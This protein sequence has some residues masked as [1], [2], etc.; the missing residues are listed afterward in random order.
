MP[1]DLQS[2]L[3]SQGVTPL[4]T[5]LFVTR[6]GHCE[7]FA[8]RDGGHVAHA[9]NPV[10]VAPVFGETYNPSPAI[11]KSAPMD[12]HAGS[13]AHIAAYVGAVRPTPAFPAPFNEPQPKT[14]A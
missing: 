14:S 6:R 9:G 11:T 1:Y 2:A 4:D 8:K 13:M 10:A 12:G 3:A 7:Y 5:F